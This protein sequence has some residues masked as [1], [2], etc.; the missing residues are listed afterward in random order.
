MTRELG[1]GRKQ[2]TGGG[3]ENNRGEGVENGDSSDEND[4]KFVDCC[5]FPHRLVVVVA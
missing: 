1:S 4:Y 3:D 2:Q 5:C